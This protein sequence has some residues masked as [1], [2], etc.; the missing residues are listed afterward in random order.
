MCAAENGAKALKL[1]LTYRAHFRSVATNGS[2]GWQK[3]V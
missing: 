2:I 1:L 3:A